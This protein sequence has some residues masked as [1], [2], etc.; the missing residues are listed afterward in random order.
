MEEKIDIKRK[1]EKKE[2]A[3]SKK[4][5]F[6]HTKNLNEQVSVEYEAKETKNVNQ[7]IITHQI[8]VDEYKGQGVSCMSF[9]HDE[10]LLAVGRDNGEIE[11]WSNIDKE[12]YYI[13]RK[14]P[15]REEST[16]RTLLW[17]NEKQERLFSCSLNGT[18]VEWD[19]EAKVPK[20]TSEYYGGAIWS[21][22]FYKDLIACA[23]ENGR[24]LLL[25]HNL[26]YVT[27]FGPNSKDKVPNVEYIKDYKGSRLL[28]VT[29]SLDE[30]LIFAGGLY[31]VYCYDDK[32]QFKYRINIETGIVWS[33]CYLEDETLVVGDSSG[34]IHFCDSKFGIILSSK[35]IS[36]AD[37]LCITADKK[38]EIVACTGVDAK[39]SLLKN[40]NSQWEVSFEKRPNYHDIKS[41]LISEKGYVLSGGLD[42]RISLNLIAKNTN[43][44]K[45][46][47]HYFFNNVPNFLKKSNQARKIIINNNDNSL[48]MI[49]V[50]N[51]NISKE[52]QITNEP[53]V[54]NEYKVKSKGGWLFSDFA[55]D[56][57]GENIA[58]IGLDFLIFYY[59]DQAFGIP[60][61]GPFGTSISFYKEDYVIIHSLDNK[62]LLYNFKEQKIDQEINLP[63]D[64]RDLFTSLPNSIS[65]IVSLENYLVVCTN[66]MVYI[67]EGLEFSQPKTQHHI[68]QNFIYKVL[69]DKDSIQILKTG[70]EIIT[71]NVLKDKSKKIDFKKSK[72]PIISVVPWK[73]QVKTTTYYNV[74]IS[75]QRALP[76]VL[77][78]AKIGVDEYIFFHKSQENMQMEKPPV[79]FRHRFGT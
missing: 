6:D 3:A 50:P 37:I 24:V 36:N 76:L 77:D 64:K 14:L 10:S 79:F 56:Q 39:V 22:C 46:G 59:K 65:Q 9:N 44:S 57:K 68:G 29:K 31:G 28:A 23:C 49:Q 19:L 18:V 70:N 35:A 73:N 51:E 16:P 74:Y 58:I 47:A 48:Q 2:F 69:E 26:E 20:K 63:K 78:C 45:L 15:G 40:I 43:E 1:R 53:E 71:I 17:L 30:T 13:I 72:D 33:L 38:G 55:I 12:R 21:M 52:N 41:V 5:S 25:N 27:S 4:K 34:Y 32:Y 62:I 60:H 54:I 8:I 75:K 42:S 7:R 67:Y 11:I 66:T 61:K